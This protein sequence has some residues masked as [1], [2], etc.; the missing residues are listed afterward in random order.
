MVYA[1]MGDKK[2]AKEKFE[3]ALKLLPEDHPEAIDSRERFNYL[4]SKI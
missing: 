4:E 3:E 1:K 2:T